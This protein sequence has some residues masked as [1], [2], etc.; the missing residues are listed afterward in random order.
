MDGAEGT[1]HVKI[2]DYN[3]AKLE[4]TWSALCTGEKLNLK[5]ISLQQ[6]MILKGKFRIV[7][8]NFCG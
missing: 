4:H 2:K 8:P 1:I 6:Y 7:V 3:I 5:I